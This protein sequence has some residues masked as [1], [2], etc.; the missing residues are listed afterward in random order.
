V[1]DLIKKILKEELD[2]KW[3]EKYKR[4][5]DCS[6]PKGFSQKAHCQGKKKKDLDEYARTLK[7]ARRQG[8]GTRFPKSAIKNSPNRFRE[9]TRNLDEN[10]KISSRYLD[11]VA[12]TIN[13]IREDD[14]PDFEWDFTEIKKN[15]ENSTLWIKTK[16]EAKKYL[17]ILKEKLKN[18]DSD[19]KRKLFKYA[20]YSLIG[21]IGYQNIKDIT[22]T[23]EPEKIELPVDVGGGLKEKDVR[24]RDYDDE[25]INH[26]KYEEGS[27]TN[28]GEPVLVA[29]DIGDGAKTIG[30]GH[31]VFS[32]PRRGDTGGNYNFLPKYN[33]I[34]PGKTRIT[35]KQA[36]TLLRDDVN[37]SRDQLNKILNDWEKEG[38]KPKITQ[39]MYNAMVSMIYNMG[40]GNFR[41]SDFIQFVKRGQMKKAQEQIKQESS[42]SFGRFPGLKIRRNN[43][44]ELFG[45]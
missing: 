29:Y 3:S 6:H 19:L 11:Q 44:S 4:S 13:L 25:L 1:K 27:I 24:I 34:I 2:E 30:Y 26:L 10:L 9:Y 12:Q 23:S 36:E 42:G 17:E 39:N 41:M 35:K 37:E 40:I 8:V 28:K 43:E 31:A 20:I 18:L 33:N 15:I 21:I 14:Q 7:M 45:R 22:T 16:E 5:I 38:I 32:N